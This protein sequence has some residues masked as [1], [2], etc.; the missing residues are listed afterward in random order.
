MAPPRKTIE[1]RFRQI[2]EDANGCWLWTGTVMKN[3]YGYLWWEDKLV[4]AHIFFYKLFRGAVPLGLVLDHTCL[5]KK[6]VNPWHQEAVT[7]KVNTLRGDGP[8]AQNA[9]QTRCIRG[10]EFDGRSERQ[11]ICRTCRREINARHYAKTR[12]RVSD[13]TEIERKKHYARVTAY[14]L[15]PVSQSCE[16]CGDPKTERHHDDYDKP[17]EVRWL[18]K[19]CHERHHALVA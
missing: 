8:S 13:K 17:L 6:C 15:L 16:R 19:S 1:D 18:C 4:R 7:N 12:L 9:R 14:R 10:H 5:V 2:V 3:G 11:R